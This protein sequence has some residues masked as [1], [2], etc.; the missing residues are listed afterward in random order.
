MKSIKITDCKLN[1][2][3]SVVIY[4][5]LAESKRGLREQKIKTAGSLMEKRVEMPYKNLLY[6]VENT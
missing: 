6:M 4:I 3:P 2:L 1:H 5:G